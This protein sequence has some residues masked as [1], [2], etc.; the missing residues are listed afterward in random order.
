MHLGPVVRRITARVPESHDGPM[1]N[2]PMCRHAFGMP[3][4]RPRSS[5]SEILACGADTLAPLET[6]MPAAPG[7]SFRSMRQVFSPTL[8]EQVISRALRRTWGILACGAGMLA[9]LDEAGILARPTSRSGNHCLRRWYSRSARGVHAC[10]AGMLASLDKAGIL[11]DAQRASILARP[12]A[13]SGNPRL[14]RW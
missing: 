2:M 3:K 1:R 8:D 10:G 11:A 9:S 7:C 14:R 13:R 4:L 5:A 6:S 12:T